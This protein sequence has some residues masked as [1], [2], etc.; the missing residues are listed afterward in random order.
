[1]IIKRIKAIQLII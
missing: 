1:M